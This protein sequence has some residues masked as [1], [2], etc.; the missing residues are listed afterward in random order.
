MALGNEVV[1]KND[2]EEEVFYSSAI[3]SE[4]EH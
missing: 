1:A 3:L 2:P 4:E